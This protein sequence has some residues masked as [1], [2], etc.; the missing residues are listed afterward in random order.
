MLMLPLP[1]PPSILAKVDLSG[2][3]KVVAIVVVAAAARLGVVFLV[4][5]DDDV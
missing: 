3:V 5:C 1:L 2:K 4:Y